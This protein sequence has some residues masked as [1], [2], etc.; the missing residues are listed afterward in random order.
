VPLVILKTDTI[1]INFT[2]K[3]RNANTKIAFGI[4]VLSV[5]QSVCRKNTKK[6]FTFM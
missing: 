1:L 5:T 4:G 3:H 6:S 2:T